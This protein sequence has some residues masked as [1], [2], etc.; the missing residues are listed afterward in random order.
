LAPAAVAHNNKGQLAGQL[1]PI[2]VLLEKLCRLELDGSPGPGACDGA[3]DGG[4]SLLQLLLQLLLAAVRGMAAW[5]HRRLPPVETHTLGTALGPR[6]KQHRFAPHSTHT[7]LCPCAALT[8]RL[9]RLLAAVRP[10]A[11]SGKEKGRGSYTRAAATTISI[12][13]RPVEQAAVEDAQNGRA[14]APLVVELEPDPAAPVAAA[15]PNTLPA[16]AALFGTAEAVRYGHFL[17]QLQRAAWQ[18]DDSAAVGAATD[19]LDPVVAATGDAAAGLPSLLQLTS[20]LASDSGGAAGGAAAPAGG[21]EVTGPFAPVSLT[22]SHSVDAAQRSITLRCA[23]VNR[24]MEEIRGVEVGVGCLWLCVLVACQ[25]NHAQ[26]SSGTVL[27]SHLARMLSAH[28]QRRKAVGAPLDARGWLATSC[29]LLHRHAPHRLPLSWPRFLPQVELTLGGPVAPGHRR[30]LSYKLD[31]LGPAAST[32]WET[33]LR[34]A[35]FGWP[36]VQAAVLL[37]VKVRRRQRH[38][39]LLEGRRGP[40]LKGRHAAGGERLKRHPNSVA[41]CWL[42][43]PWAVCPG[44]PCQPSA[45]RHRSKP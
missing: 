8:E 36:A 4:A 14:E 2:G 38:R 37:P 17:E 24:T 1:A 20:L 34:V 33:E 21:L 41:A 16:A 27:A 11:T 23:V 31:P 29:C 12:R 44:L 5:L 19:D 7:S 42:Q 18:D 9:G 25:V 26:P 3:A 22:L 6:G 35:G 28:R 30:P 39:L 43:K 15:Y 32:A 45:C 13:S 10:V 40:G